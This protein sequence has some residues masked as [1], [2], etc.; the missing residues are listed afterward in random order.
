MILHESCPRDGLDFD[1]FEPSGMPNA[2]VASGQCGFFDDAHYPDTPCSWEGRATDFYQNACAITLESKQHPLSF[3]TLDGGIGV[4][5]HAYRGDGA[6]PVGVLA[7]EQGL[8]VGA[9]LWYPPE[10]VGDECEAGTAD[11]DRD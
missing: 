5:S 7:D 11:D 2:S 4:V 1:A 6:Y 9:M 3:G 10:D 8:V